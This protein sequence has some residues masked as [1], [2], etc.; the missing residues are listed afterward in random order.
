M[1][2]CGRGFSIEDEKNEEIRCVE[3]EEKEVTRKKLELVL[4]EKKEEALSKVKTKKKK[5]D[6]VSFWRRTIPR[7]VAKSIFMF[8]DKNKNGRLCKNEWYYL[9]ESYGMEEHAKEL[10]ALIDA[11]GGGDICWSEFISWMSRTNYFVFDDSEKSDT[12]FSVL[13]ALAEKFKSYD[14]DDDG[15]ITKEEFTAVKKDWH[16]P[17]DQNTF[18]NLVDKDGNNKVTFNEYYNFFFQPYMKSYYPNIFGSIV[19]IS[20]SVTIV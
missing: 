13:L 18:F 14:T 7:H 5:R 12:R 19:R 16:Y 6:S 9:L 15:F 20:T 11:D 8:F 1:A 3:D 17:V 10:A 2:V 4:E